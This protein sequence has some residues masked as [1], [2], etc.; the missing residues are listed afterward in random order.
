MRFQLPPLR[1]GVRLVVVIDVARAG[2]LPRVLWTIRR[3]SLLTRTDQKF[4]SFALSSLWKLRPGFAGFSLQVEGRRLDGLLLVAGQAGEAVGEG[5]GDA[6]FHLRP[7]L[8][9][10]PPCSSSRRLASP[11][12]P[13]AHE[14]LSLQTSPRMTSFIA[15]LGVEPSSLRYPTFRAPAFSELE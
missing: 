4:L 7:E 12:S 3:M 9:T 15:S 1:P 5:V 2:G 10:T 6:E 14:V 13:A 11:P 8:C